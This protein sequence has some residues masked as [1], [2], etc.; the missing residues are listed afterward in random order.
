MP[1]IK[2]GFCF[3]AGTSR[4]DDDFAR[5]FVSSPFQSYKVVNLAS[6]LSSSLIHKSLS[7]T[8]SSRLFYT[9]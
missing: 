7:S 6:A 2:P 3:I 9:L 4:F 8:S 1:G 5:V